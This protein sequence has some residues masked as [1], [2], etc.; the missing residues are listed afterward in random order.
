MTGWASSGHETLY[1]VTVIVYW[2]NTKAPCISMGFACFT[3]MKSVAWETHQN[4]VYSN[5][6]LTLNQSIMEI[7]FLFTC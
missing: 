7:H 3:E 6:K 4:K 5:F 2:P 1:E